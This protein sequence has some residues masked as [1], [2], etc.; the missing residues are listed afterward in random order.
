MINVIDKCKF[1]SCVRSGNIKY[2][3][4]CT[5]CYQHLFPNDE[6]SKNIRVKTKEN[7]VRDFLKGTFEGFIHDIPLWTGNCDCSHRRRIDFRKLIGN[8]L[9]CIEV[10]ENQ[11][12]RYKEKDEEIRYDDLFML[13]GGKF[14]FIRF[15][16]DQFTNS[17]D[18][19]KNP[20]MKRR[21]EYLEKEIYNQIN[22]IDNEENKDLLEISYLFYD[23][24]EYNL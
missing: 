24:F 17:L 19:K 5:F 15:N 21:M 20:Y 1:E 22:R 12:K 4:Y 14:V 23:N 3:Y 7:Y 6:T 18:T 10:D 16:P 9:L 13:H 2:K 8:T 11:H